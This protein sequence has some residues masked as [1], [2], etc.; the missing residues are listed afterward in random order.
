MSRN[1]LSSEAL[2]NLF[3]LMLV[4]FILCNLIHV[5]FEPPPPRLFLPPIVCHESVLPP[6]VPLSALI[7]SYYLIRLGLCV[8]IAPSVRLMSIITGLHAV[9]F[10]R[11]THGCRTC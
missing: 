1:C 8:Q 10:C 2:C 11:L 5:L 3:S 6:P 9:E 4:S 7:V